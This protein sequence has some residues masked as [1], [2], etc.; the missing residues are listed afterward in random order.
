V[1]FVWN[2]EERNQILSTVEPCYNDVGLCETS[3]MASDILWYQ[4]IPHC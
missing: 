4:L 3:P 1:T 2:I